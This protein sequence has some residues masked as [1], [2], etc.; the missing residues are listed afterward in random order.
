MSLS[1]LLLFLCIQI[2]FCQI[3]PECIPYA[4]QNGFSTKGGLIMMIST[5]NYN[6]RSGVMTISL[7]FQITNSLNT[8]YTTNC[9]VYGSTGLTVQSNVFTNFTSLNPVL[10]KFQYAANDFANF[11]VVCSVEIETD[12]E[13][14]VTST[15]WPSVFYAGFTTTL[16]L[17]AGSY[18]CNILR[19][20]NTTP[21]YSF[22]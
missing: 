17:G 19:V 13:I 16:S 3:S 12:V 6:V 8:K 14:F 7:P 20:Y 2:V 22:G 9:T 1:W 5:P 21:V 18:Y 15:M 10:I 4:I 11:N